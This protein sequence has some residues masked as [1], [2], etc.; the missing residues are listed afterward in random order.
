MTPLISI[1][2]VCFNAEDVIETTLKSVASQTF[3]DYEHVIVDGA[4]KDATLS[5]IAGNATP[6]LS[7]HSAPDEGIYHGMNR[8]LEYARGRYVLFLNAGD[9]FASHDTLAKYAE[10]IKD[11]P[12]IIYG[13]TLIV[14][15]AGNIL[16]KRHLDAPE[17]L[18]HKSF[19]KGMLICHQAFMV[20][21]DIAPHYNREFR[22]SADYDWCIRCIENSRITRRRNLR[23]VTVHYLDG[24][25][26]EHHKLA[27]L[28]ERF[29]IMKRQY[30]L[31]ATLRSH[32]SFIPRALR[33]KFKTGSPV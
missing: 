13:D 2:T 6:E 15:E 20:R 17:V 12:D 29:V 25:T 32:L 14:D 7:L 21:R 10:A 31:A 16:R 27:S 9:K 22:Y 23:C 30:G 18:T 33:R 1:I 4:S 5:I 3:R 19:L 11:D 24:G 28:R 8:G 26:T